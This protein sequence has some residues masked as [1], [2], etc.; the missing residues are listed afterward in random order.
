MWRAILS[1][2]I[3]L[4][5]GLGHSVSQA[6][7]PPPRILADL[8]LIV[9]AGDPGL[10]QCIE[11]ESGTL[12]I[13]LQRT[14]DLGGGPVAVTFRLSPFVVA[15]PILPAL[16]PT[17]TPVTVSAPI[18]GGVYCY[19]LAHPQPWMNRPESAPL[20]QRI[21]LQLTWQP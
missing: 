20:G 8:P 1:G 19:S 9:M 4:G 13:R 12:T 3:I 18:T 7:G 11:L 10:P 14:G 5:L 2:L 6:Q 17:D 15:E 21:H 16:T